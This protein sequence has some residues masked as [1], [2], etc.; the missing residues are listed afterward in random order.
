M[1]EIIQFPRKIGGQ[2]EQDRPHPKPVGHEMPLAAAI[3]NRWMMQLVFTD[4]AIVYGCIS[5]FDKWTITVYLEGSDDPITYFKHAL[6]SFS[7][8]AD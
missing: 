2:D 6:K 1:R 4:G 5:A 8:A 3:K 7:R